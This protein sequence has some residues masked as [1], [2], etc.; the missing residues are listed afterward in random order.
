MIDAIESGIYNHIEGDGREYVITE[1]T[2]LKVYAEDGRTINNLD[3]LPFF[4]QEIFS[5]ERIDDFSTI[6]SFCF[7]THGILYQIGRASCR[8]RVF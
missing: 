7:S 5:G 3:M 8:E 4:K 6:L 2:A 1:E